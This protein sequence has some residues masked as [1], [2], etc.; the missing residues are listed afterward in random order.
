MFIGAT[1]RRGLAPENEPLSH[2]RTGP[3][4]ERSMTL[5]NVSK[6]HRFVVMWAQRILERISLHD[7]YRVLT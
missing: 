6:R 7:E 4:D 2:A 3:N 1:N 5:A